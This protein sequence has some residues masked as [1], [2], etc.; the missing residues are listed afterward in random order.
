LSIN[1]S[2]RQQRG[3]TFAKSFKIGPAYDKTKVG[4]AI[5]Q[6]KF[7]YTLNTTDCS[8]RNSGNSRCGHDY[9]TQLPPEEKKACLNI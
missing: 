5:E 3:L 9:G 4:L 6:T 1:P 7:D 8:D 2:G